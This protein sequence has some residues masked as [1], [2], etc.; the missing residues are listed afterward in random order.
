MLEDQPKFDR[1]TLHQVELES[2][3]ELMWHQ[4]QL[5]YQ[6]SS[7]LHEPNCKQ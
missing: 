1:Q 7:P 2:K 6:E 5:D 3:V 4:V